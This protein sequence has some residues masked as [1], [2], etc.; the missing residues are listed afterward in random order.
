MADSAHQKTAHGDLDNHGFGDI[1]E[2]FVV[3]HEAA[4]ACEPAE[5]SLH[6]TP[7]ACL[8]AGRYIDTAHHFDWQVDE[9]GFVQQLPSIIGAVGEERREPWPARAD[10]FEDHLRADA[11][12]DV[13]RPEIDHQPPPIGVD[14][15]VALAPDHLLSRAVAALRP[16]RWC[17]DSIVCDDTRAGAGFAPGALTIVHQGDVVH[18]EKQDQPYKA[19]EGDRLPG[20]KV[21]LDHPRANDRARHVAGRVENLAQVNAQPA[22]PPGRLRQQWRNSLAFLIGETGRIALCLRSIRAIRPRMSCVHMHGPQSQFGR[23]GIKGFSRER[24]LT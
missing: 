5:G 22:T 8:D 14:R 17:L 18:H 7:G 6:P 11:V 10:G 19:P 12:G 15:V 20:R 16:R 1:D 21:L 3:A 9:G 24:G 23:A 2:S 13:D 4:P